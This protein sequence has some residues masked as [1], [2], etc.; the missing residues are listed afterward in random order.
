MLQQCLHD[1]HLVLAVHLN[2]AVKVAGQLGG[3]ITE[4]TGRQAGSQAGN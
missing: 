4:G 3:V 1:C 2:I